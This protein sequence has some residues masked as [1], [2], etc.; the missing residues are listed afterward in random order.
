MNNQSKIK[1][2]QV[3]TCNISGPNLLI[4]PVHRLLSFISDITQLVENLN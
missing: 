2:H 3:Y 1:F 4:P